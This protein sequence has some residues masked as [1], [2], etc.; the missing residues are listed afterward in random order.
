MAQM[1]HPIHVTFTTF[2]S[3]IFLVLVKNMRV[4]LLLVG[5]RALMLTVIIFAIA[6]SDPYIM[7]GQWRDL[8]PITLALIG[9]FLLVLPY[10][11]LTLAID[12]HR[13]LLLGERRDIFGVSALRWVR[14]YL[15]GLLQIQL[16]NIAVVVGGGWLLSHQAVLI[17]PFVRSLLMLGLWVFM[18]VVTMHL[19]T[20]LP[21]LA[22]GRRDFSFLDAWRITRRFFWPFLSAVFVVVFLVMCMLQSLPLLPAPVSLSLFILDIF[23]ICFISCMILL[24]PLTQITLAYFLGAVRPDM[25]RRRMDFAMRPMPG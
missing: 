11:L 8:A 12:W 16:L 21:A 7:A 9:L 22:L 24:I 10:S 5:A 18:L 17:P 23:I 14:F 1:T 20:R 13:W 2:F 25:L 3:H 15:A 4:G 19:V 6:A